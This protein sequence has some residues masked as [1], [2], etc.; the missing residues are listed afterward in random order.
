MCQRSVSVYV[1]SKT[2][3]RDCV[4]IKSSNCVVHTL[5][6]VIC[7]HVTGLSS[8]GKAVYRVNFTFKT[9]HFIKVIYITCTW[10][11]YSP[12]SDDKVEMYLFSGPKT[13][14]T[15]GFSAART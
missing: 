9:Y 6:Y 5:R 14:K 3:F 12:L 7:G 15:T 10:Y 11:V 8:N 1:I 13:F 4:I 2:Q